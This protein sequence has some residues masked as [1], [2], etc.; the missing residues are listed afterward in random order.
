[1]TGV[2]RI[3]VQISI[4]GQAGK[5]D[6]SRVQFDKRVGATYDALMMS[7]DGQTLNATAAGITAAGRAL[8]VASDPNDPASV[9]LA[10]KNSDMADFTCQ[11]VYDT[12]EGDGSADAE[13][14]SWEEILTFDIICS[15]S[16]VD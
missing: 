13:G 7:D 1:M 10:S 5:D 4:K 3:A 12:G 16:N 15:P 9:D 11:A 2:R 6:S 8:A 14:C